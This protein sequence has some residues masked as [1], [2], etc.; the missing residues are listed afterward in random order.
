MR[1]PTAFSDESFDFFI[2]C[3][4]TGHRGDV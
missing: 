2:R 1:R 3:P 4:Q